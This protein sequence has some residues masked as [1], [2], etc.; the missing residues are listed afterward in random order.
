ME[1]PL[2]DEHCALLNQ[3]LRSCSTLQ[4]YLEKLIAI[5][6]PFDQQ[7]QESQGNEGL[8]TQL[9]ALHFPNQP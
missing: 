6:V 8:A 4:C 1:C 3:T 7:M 5:G 2:G 9:K